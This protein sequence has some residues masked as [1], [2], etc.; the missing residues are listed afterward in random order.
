ML[1]VL[2]FVA[3]L[4]SGFAPQCQTIELEWQGSA[5]HCM[6]RGQQ[7]VARW[8]ADR[9]GYTLRGGYRCANGRAA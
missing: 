9:R 7:E 4:N 1:V 2:S 5:F 3:C 8:L 6:M